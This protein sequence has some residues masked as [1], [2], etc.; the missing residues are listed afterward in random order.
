MKNIVLQRRI[1]VRCWNVLGMVAKASKRPEL[2]P[3]LI[4]ARE[5]HQTSAEDIAEHLFFE[6]RA[7]R[8]VAERLLRIAASYGLIG[9]GQVRIH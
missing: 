6:Q 8:V 2:M 9:G 1:A 7:R 3:V 5:R 4:R